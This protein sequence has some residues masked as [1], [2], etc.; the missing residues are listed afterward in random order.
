MENAPDKCRIAFRDATVRRQHVATIYTVDASVFL[1]AFNPHEEGYEHSHRLLSEMQRQAI[2]VV[3]PSLLLPEVAGVVARAQDD[4]Q[5][6]RRFALSLSRLPHLTLVPLDSSLAK[7]A[8][9]VAAQHRL[10]GSDAVYAAVSLQYG[11]VL[12]TL[13]KEQQRRVA[14]VIAAHR[15]VDVLLGDQ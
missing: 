9:D 5:L 1:N 3:V 15:P 4:A 7:R 11:S 10:R 8:A 2:P 12:V 6:A 13:D 14:N